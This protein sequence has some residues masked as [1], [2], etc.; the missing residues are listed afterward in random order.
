M[1]LQAISTLAGLLSLGFT[2]IAVVV[3]AIVLGR[4]TARQTAS[5]AQK[6]AIDA[7]QSELETLR[8]RIDDLKEENVRQKEETARQKLIVETICAALKAEGMVITVQGEMIHIQH[9]TSST[10]TKIQ[11]TLHSMP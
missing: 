10:T 1:D 9:G 5:D 11:G 3:G 4:N 6:N 2:V 7:M 8:G